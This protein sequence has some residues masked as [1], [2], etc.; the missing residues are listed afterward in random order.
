MPVVKTSE[1]SELHER[2][3]HISFNTLKSLPECPKFH[4][5]PRCEACEKGK[6]TKPPARNQQKTDPKIR[7][8]RPLERIHADL[9]GPIKPVTPGN[10]FKYLLTTTDDFSRYVVTKPIKMKSDTTDALIEII[11]AF[12][13]ACNPPQTEQQLTLKV[14]QVQA[15]W[16]GEFRNDRLAKKLRK[17]GIQLKET[18]PGHSETNAIIERTNRTIMTMNRT[19]IL[20]TNGGIPKGR[21]DKA[22]GWSAHTK[23]RV[24]HKT[25]EG[26]SPLEILFPGKDIHNERKN[27]RP[28][29]QEV[30]CFDYNVTDKLSARS[31]EARIV[32]YTLTHGVYQVIDK[33]ERQRI[34]KDSKPLNLTEIESSDYSSEEDAD[35]ES[36]NNT[37]IKNTPDE[38]SFT[39][40]T[41][42]QPAPAKQQR[43]RKTP[44]E[45]T[46][47]YGSR[48]STREKQPSPKART[49]AIGADE[50]HHTE[51][52]ARNGNNATE[53]ATARQREREQLQAYG[54]YSKI[55]KEQI[56]VGTK[57]VDTKWIYTVKRRPNGE[58]EKFKARKVGRGFTQEHGI[59]YDETYAQMMRPETW[60]ML[61]VIALYHEWEIRQWDV[62]A[63]YLQADLDPRHKVYIEDTNENGE[64]EYWIL[65]KALYG[66]KQ[67]GHEWYEKLRKVLTDC[68][69]TQCVGDEGSY[70]G[71]ESL[72]GTH[73]DDFLA[74]GKP[75][76]LDYIEQGIQRHVELDKR[77]RPQKMLGIEMTWK[78]NGSGVLLT[79]SGLIENLAKKHGIVGVKT[80]MPLAQHYFSTITETDI[81]C[82]KMMYQQMVGGLLYLSRMT[83]PEASI[84]VNLLGRRSTNPSTM[85]MEGAKDLLRYFLSTKMEGIQINKPEN[86]NV[87][88]YADASYGDPINNSG[89]SQSGAMVTVGGQ[90]VNWWTRKQDV[91]SL[92]ITEAEY[93]ADCEGAKDA[94]AMRQLTS[95]MKIDTNTPILMTD[96][97]GALNLSKTSKFQR[98]SRHIEHRFHYLRQETNKGHLNIQHIPGKQN[99]ADVLTK[100]T[101]MTTI[102]NWMK[103]WMG[104]MNGKHNG[105]SG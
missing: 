61:L 4:T 67:A 8:T 56:P 58:V 29:G 7:T 3:G 46:A 65:H 79:Q 33:N 25:L 84:Q 37:P 102:R 27:L 60:R 68:D 41:P 94:A 57:I 1:V 20:G 35:N 2:Y 81:P 9:I 13:T 10:Q 14:H 99:P 71:Q 47:L 43:H 34:A 91:V 77:G 82:D 98:R 6:A 36:E 83:R 64:T 75:K 88:I 76:N 92:S 50:D 59:N 73:V 78:K 5:K 55:K 23:N 105:M 21:W 66:L 90:L 48:Q 62:V 38:P 70:F 86:L 95:E 15:D 39:E 19:A 85:N 96:S 30:V 72:I 12:E 103:N 44:E 26:K 32:G 17:K 28:F 89:K 87:V 93:I 40:H 45:F 97:E 80:S 24:P 69:L 54:V 18:V 53:W 11:D 22:S 52:Q 51:Q 104:G 49:Q 31:Y 42:S 74:V 100:I 16:G 101:P 63:A